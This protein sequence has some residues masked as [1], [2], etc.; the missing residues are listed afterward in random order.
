MRSPAMRE[1][2]LLSASPEVHRKQIEGLRRQGTRVR[3]AAAPQ[4][5][6]D[7]LRSAPPLVLVDLIHGP[8]VSAEVVETLNHA[9][10]VKRVIVLHQ[11]VLDR[12][13][14]EV[15]DLVVDGFFRDGDWAGLTAD[16]HARPRG[17]LA[18]TQTSSSHRHRSRAP[19]RRS[20][21]ACG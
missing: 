21:A 3:A 12:F 4:Q 15:A 7:L 14:E 19:L 13:Q 11:G 1:V 5:A 17:R 16:S 20:R 10:G 8:G 2:V 18:L 9:R 6:L